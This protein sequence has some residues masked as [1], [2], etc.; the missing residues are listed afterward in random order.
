MKTQAQRNA[1]YERVRRELGVDRIGVGP[2]S[3][4]LPPWSGDVARKAGAALPIEAAM[5]GAQMHEYGEIWARPGLDLR[6]R[7]FIT[8]ATLTAL[9]YEKQLYRHINS[10]LNLG[11]TPE[12][13]H[14][15]LLHATSYC[16]FAAWEN[17]VTVATEV[18]VVRGI[19][20]PGEGVAVEPKPPM[21]EKQRREAALRLNAELGVGRLGLGPDAPLLKALPGGPVLAN[22]PGTLAGEIAYI[23][24]D[25]GYGELW[26]RG[27]LPLRIRS[28]ITCAIL[29]AM[30]ENHQLHIHICNALNIGISTDEMEEALAQVGLYHG[31]SGWHNAVTVA[32]HVFEQHPAGVG[33]AAAA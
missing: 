11:I 7:A 25:Y 26:G 29:Q 32:R 5:H 23:G 6:T 2:D 27:G 19:L 20:P 8:V 15:T 3:K 28:F 14:E 4:P 9:G 24:A 1:D 10:A 13:I 22:K 12:E 30:V 33:Q 18:F 16:G 17:A 31:V 21:D